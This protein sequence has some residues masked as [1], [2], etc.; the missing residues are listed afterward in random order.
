M[1]NKI[2]LANFRNFESRTFEFSDEL[3]VIVGPNASGKTNI[4]ESVVL[5]STAKSFKARMEEE[6]I[7]YDYELSRIQGKA[8]GQD[9]NKLEVVLT[10]GQITRGE[11]TERVARKRLLVNGAGRRMVDFASHFTTVLFRPQDMELVT[12]SPSMR[13]KFIDNVLSQ[14]NRQ[15][16]ANLLTYQKALRRRNKLLIKIREEGLSRQSL[17]FWNNLLIKNGSYI[18]E[19]RAE[20][21]HFVNGIKS[22]NQGDY[23]IDYDSSVISEKRLEQ[24]AR[25]EVAAASTLVG[26]HRDDLIFK[27][28][29]R[30]LSK[31][32][33]RGEQR[34]GVLWVKL[35]ELEFITKMSDQKPTLLLDDIFSELDREHRELVIEKVYDQQTIMTT[36]DPRF[37]E[38]LSNFVKIELG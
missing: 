22:L 15:Y 18:T 38:D 28:N 16:R 31:Y 25:A 12:G 24:Y 21:I 3:S 4:V 37:L 30:E 9:G 19:K 1:L 11:V 5:L 7:R 36:A 26:P 33:S 2:N 13:R 27:L 23:K 14:A 17:Y 29:G 32:G 8:S 35:A 6:M 10:R 20:F 34:M